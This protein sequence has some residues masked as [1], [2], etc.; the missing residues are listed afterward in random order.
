MR[1]ETFVGQDGHLFH[2]GGSCRSRPLPFFH[3][4]SER[5]PY[6][7]FG[8]IIRAEAPLRLDR[9]SNGPVQILNGVGR[10]DQLADGQRKSK[11]RN[12]A[13]P[14]VPPHARNPCIVLPKL[15]GVESFERCQGG[16]SRRR[17]VD[18]FDGGGMRRTIF[19]AHAD[20][21]VAD[22][23]HDAR[24]RHRVSNVLVSPFETVCDGNQNVFD[25]AAL[26]LA[27]HGE[28]E[29]SAFGVIEPKPQN[30]LRAVRSDCAGPS[31]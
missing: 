15:A 26:E 19:A 4:A 30:V 22:E 31:E 5:E 21:A 28:P 18:G 1:R 3:D 10:A 25:A 17:R 12:H 6:D 7:L 20:Q 11:E 14:C 24:L 2:G 23:M 9:L 29:G 16:L 13:V 27:E 8:C